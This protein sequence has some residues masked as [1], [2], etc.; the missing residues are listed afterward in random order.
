MGEGEYQNP[1]TIEE[2]LFD[3]V[4]RE[5]LMLLDDKE[6]ALNVGL[7]EADVYGV[8]KEP[9][10]YLLYCMG[11]LVAKRNKQEQEAELIA[12]STGERE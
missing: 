3:G 10:G 8:I 11:R 5:L 1:R 2:K 4:E 12:R 7:Y 6:L 9:K